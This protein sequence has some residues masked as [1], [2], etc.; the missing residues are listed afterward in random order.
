MLIGVDY[1]KRMRIN[2]MR[3]ANASISQHPINQGLFPISVFPL[4]KKPIE[5]LND[6]R[7]IRC[8]G[9]EDFADEFTI[10]EPRHPCALGQLKNEHLGEGSILVIS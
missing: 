9:V 7:M 2:M 3:Y 6:A 1:C 8:V 10:R 5:H 4:G